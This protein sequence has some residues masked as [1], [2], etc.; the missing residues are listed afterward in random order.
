[1]PCGPKTPASDRAQIFRA[2]GVGSETG[3]SSLRQ[4]HNFHT[5]LISRSTAK[6]IDL[7]QRKSAKSRLGFGADPEKGRAI[8]W[9]MVANVVLPILHFYGYKIANP[10]ILARVVLGLDFDGCHFELSHRWNCGAP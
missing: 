3:S 6:K 7:N 5:K 8:A 4:L 10:C 2:I 9:R 1:M